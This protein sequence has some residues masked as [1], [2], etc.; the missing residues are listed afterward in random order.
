[1]ITVGRHEKTG[2]ATDRNDPSGR[3]RLLYQC[4]D[5][6][7]RHTSHRTAAPDAVLLVVTVLR[8]RSR[9]WPALLARARSC[10]EYWHVSRQLALSR[11]FAESP[12][13]SARN[14]VEAQVLG[15]HGTSQVLCLVPR[16][17]SRGSL[18]D[19]LAPR[20][21][22]SESFANV[23]SRRVRFAN[24]SISE[25]TMRANFGIV[26]WPRA[27][28]ESI[29]RDERA[30]IPRRLLQ[31]AILRA[32]IGCGRAGRA[33]L[34]RWCGQVLDRRC[35]STSGHAQ[36]SAGIVKKAAVRASDDAEPNAGST[37]SRRRRVATALFATYLPAFALPPPP[38]HLL[39]LRQLIH[40]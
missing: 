27:S 6:Q 22:P 1:M 33:S 16:R 19:A 11:A 17:V 18:L 9:I 38:A 4:R 36:R 5:I 34:A 24:I 12:R 29:L 14:S 26:M 7:G 28:A 25:G 39:S 37:I 2:G 23:S 30:V 10:A 32:T 8:I 35:P 3:L 13:R 15:E 20:Q 31:R 40:Y 21:G